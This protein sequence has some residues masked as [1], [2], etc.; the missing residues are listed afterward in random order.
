VRQSVVAAKL[1]RNRRWQVSGTALRAL[2]S[3]IA[4][5]LCD[6]TRGR[7][8]EMKL[9]AIKVEVEGDQIIATLPG[10][11]FRAVYWRSDDPS[12]LR[13]SPAVSVDKEAPNHVHREFEQA[14]W[15]AATVRARE[16]GWIA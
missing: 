1:P 7:V 12:A 3:V 14:G 16:L 11:H 13:Q 9:D 15:E 4:L 6:N 2:A 10:T 8:R 5:F